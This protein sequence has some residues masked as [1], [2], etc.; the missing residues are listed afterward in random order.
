M[1]ELHPQ[2]PEDA[3]AASGK[4]NGDAPKESFDAWAIVELMGHRK[5]AGRVS[6]QV[7]A[8]CPLLRIDVPGTEKGQLHIYARQYYSLTPTT[9]A[10]CRAY[11]AAYRGVNP[12]VRIARVMNDARGL[13]AEEAPNEQRTKSYR[14]AEARA[15]KRVLPKCPLRRNGRVN[16]SS[17]VLPT[18]SNPQ[19]DMTFLVP[20]CALCN[21][22]ITAQFVGY[23]PRQA[24]VAT[25]PGNLWTPGKGN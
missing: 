18:P 17:I 8:G 12:G 24:G 10:I 5:L 21:K 6:E 25:P 11:A 22:I 15:R 14:K 1:K 13:D 19:G 16:V 4:T 2:G 23:T 7:I 3:A 9:E 20:C